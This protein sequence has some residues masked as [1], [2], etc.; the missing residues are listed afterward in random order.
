[1]AFTKIPFQITHQRTVSSAKADV[2]KPKVR[3]RE[4][5]G[6]IAVCQWTPGVAHI[7]CKRRAQLGQF[8]EAPLVKTLAL[9]SYI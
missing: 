9:A 8:N 7:S 5:H 1:M 4:V 6:S 2:I 3:D